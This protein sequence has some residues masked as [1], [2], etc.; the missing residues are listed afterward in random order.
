MNSRRKRSKNP[1]RARKAEAG[2]EEPVALGRAVVDAGQIIVL[3]ERTDGQAMGI[4]RIP[5]LPLRSDVVFPQTVVPLVINRP[6]GI[7]LIDDAMVG[8][9]MIALVSQLHPETDAPVMDDLFPTVCVGLVLKMLKFPDGS[10]RIVC[11]GQYRARLL[12]V[13][14]A[15][16]VP[17][18]RDRAVRGDRRGGRRARRAG[19]PRQPVLPADGGPEPADP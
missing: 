19:P 17:D 5:L 6:S 14:Q 9:R 10:T 12:S 18:R 15:E 3:G 13:V 11:Q 1:N 7:R 4:C 8:E 16:P 2:R